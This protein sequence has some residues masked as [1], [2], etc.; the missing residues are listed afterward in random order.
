MENGKNGFYGIVILELKTA[1]SNQEILEV[2][3]SMRYKFSKANLYH[4]T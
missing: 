4:I 2:L 1:F 3:V